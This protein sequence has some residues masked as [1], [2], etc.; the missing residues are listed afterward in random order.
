MKKIIIV[1]TVI[2]SIIS[3]WALNDFVRYIQ[4]DDTLFVVDE[5][6]LFKQYGSEWLGEPGIYQFGER[7]KLK[8]VNGEAKYI[9]NEKTMA[10]SAGSIQIIEKGFKDI[11]YD[12]ENEI[13]YVDRMSDGGYENVGLVVDEIDCVQFRKLKELTDQVHNSFMMRNHENG[14][15]LWFF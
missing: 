3:G 2:T 7:V 12:N 6:T 11:F 1:L 9:N 8:E 10:I 14:I 4:R 15:E 13:E 5:D